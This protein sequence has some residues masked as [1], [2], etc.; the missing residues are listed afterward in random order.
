[1]EELP[2]GRKMFLLDKSSDNLPRSSFAKLF[3]YEKALLSVLP[4][5]NFGVQLPGSLCN[6]RGEAEHLTF[7]GFYDCRHAAQR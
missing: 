2:I 7:F 6:L 5:M 1:M 4:H 3:R